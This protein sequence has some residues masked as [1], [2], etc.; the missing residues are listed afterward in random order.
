LKLKLGRNVNYRPVGSKS[1]D[2]ILKFESNPEK[3]R[4][5]VGTN[6]LTNIIDVVEPLIRKEFKYMRAYK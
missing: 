4:N 1:S 3:N 5:M 6:Y 2:Q